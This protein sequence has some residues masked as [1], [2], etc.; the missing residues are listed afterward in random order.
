MAGLGVEGRILI[1]LRR[2]DIEIAL[3]FRNL[4]QT[5]CIDVAEL[6]AYDVLVND[7]IIFTTETLPSTAPDTEEEG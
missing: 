6:N 3:S 4:P 1:V 2:H 7:W 5:Q